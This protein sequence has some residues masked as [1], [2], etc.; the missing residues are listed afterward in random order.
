MHFSFW[1]REREE[2][3]KEKKRKKKGKSA[4]NV[5]V[6]VPLM[7]EMSLFRITNLRIIIDCT[8]I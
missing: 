4:L 7:G 2:R 1:E 6:S 8:L 5:L 3:G